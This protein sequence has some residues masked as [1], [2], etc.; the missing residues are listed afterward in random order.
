MQFNHID[1]KAEQDARRFAAISKPDTLIAETMGMLA[2]A[3]EIKCAPALDAEFHKFLFREGGNHQ[4]LI[5]EMNAW[6]Q[7]WYKANLASEGE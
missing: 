3:K 7:G 5:S 4:R 2:F 6:I 1:Y